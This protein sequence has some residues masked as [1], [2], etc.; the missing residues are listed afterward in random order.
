MFENYG[1]KREQ[2]QHINVRHMTNHM[3]ATFLKPY[4]QGTL[5]E[6]LMENPAMY[7]I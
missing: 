7:F 2:V 4:F 1:K 5:I 3:P 6:E